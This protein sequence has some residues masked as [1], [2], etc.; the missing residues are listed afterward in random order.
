MINKEDVVD[1]KYHPVTVELFEHL[2]GRIEGLK[3][4]IADGV[5]S[6]D[7]RLLAFKAGAIQA[8][9]DILDTDF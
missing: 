4:E 1:W 6:S 8:L 5:L 3:T 7:P 9:Q 2:R